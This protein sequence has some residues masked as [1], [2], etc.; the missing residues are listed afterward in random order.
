MNNYKR[1][2]SLFIVSSVTMGYDRQDCSVAL[3][4][5]NFLY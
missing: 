1:A 4:T 3:T 5:P 2:Q